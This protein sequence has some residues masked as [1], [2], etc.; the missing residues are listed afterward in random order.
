MKQNWRI[1]VITAVGV[2]VVIPLVVYLHNLSKEQ[3]LLQLGEHQ[4]LHAENLTDQIESLY[5]RHYIDLNAILSFCRQEGMKGLRK[6]LRLYPDRIGGMYTAGRLISLYD[7][8]GQT[9]YS[10]ATNSIEDQNT[11]S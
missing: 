6:T 4:L 9:I 5:C 1:I 10:T 7:E 11:L 3:V 2:M 8:S